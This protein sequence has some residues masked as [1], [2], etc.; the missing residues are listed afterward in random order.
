MI[1]RRRHVPRDTRQ[2]SFDESTINVGIK[3]YMAVRCARSHR[4]HDFLERAPRA[5]IPRA[6]GNLRGLRCSSG[7][8]TFALEQ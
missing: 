5:N 6:N 4:E 3:R 8:T 1:R 7:F 2:F